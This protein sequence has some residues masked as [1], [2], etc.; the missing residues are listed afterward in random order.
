MKYK[1]NK[2]SIKNIFDGGTIIER[3][4]FQYNC[5]SYALHHNKTKWIWSEYKPED[6]PFLGYTK[7]K[8]KKAKRG[9]LVVFCDDNNTINHYAKFIRQKKT[10]G[11][12]IIISKCGAGMLWKSTIA[13]C[14]S[15]HI[16]YGDIVL[17]FKKTNKNK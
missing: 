9:D 7:I 5:E 2:N 8:F 14:A 16:G 3:R 4:N 10:V 15:S 17:F 12:S 6:I 13:Q 11:N 1:I